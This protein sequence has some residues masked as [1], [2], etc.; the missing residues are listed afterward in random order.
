M[1]VF[2]VGPFRRRRTGPRWCLL[3]RCSGGIAGDVRGST[4]RRLRSR[5]DGA[6]RQ[7]LEAGLMEAGWPFASA[8]MGLE[9]CSFR[10]PLFPRNKIGSPTNIM[11]IEDLHG[12]SMLQQV[13][14]CHAK[15][16][17]SGESGIS[18]KNIHAWPDQR[19][20]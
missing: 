10:R 19:Q 4:G 16:T 20:T 15:S 9:S 1:E 6:R 13:P 5:C 7:Y 18:C 2:S 11:P 17:P 14:R 12:F 3:L 8:P